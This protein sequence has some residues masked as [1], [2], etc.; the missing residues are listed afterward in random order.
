MIAHG[1]DR[2]ERSD[3]VGLLSEAGE[4]GGGALVF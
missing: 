4:I 1:L 2:R 3:V